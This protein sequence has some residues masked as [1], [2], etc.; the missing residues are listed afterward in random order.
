MN[1]ARLKAPLAWRL[2]L[3]ELR[4]GLSGFWVL[5]LCL[6]LGVAAI[7]GVASVRYSI[8]QGIQDEGQNILGG[9]AQME[10]T[11]R[12]ASDDEL[13]W[14]TQNA[15]AHSVV[16][17]FR[18]MLTHE[19]VRGLTDVK[20]VDDLYPLAGHVVLDPQMPLEDAF[21]GAGGLPGAVLDPLLVR[22]LELALGDTVQI[23]GQSFIYM[24]TL[25]REPDSAGAGFG[26]GPRSMVALSALEDTGL[27][28]PGTLFNTSYRLLAETDDLDQLRASAQTDL[29]QSGFQW[30]DKR[31]GAPGLSELVARLSAF[32]V[33]VGLA[34]LAVGGVGVSSA[35]R[36]YLDRK[37]HV[38]ATLKTLGAE[39]SL[40][41]GI[42]F[43]QIGL[44]TLIAVFA[45]LFV[46]ALFP[47][48]AVWAFGDQLPIPISPQ[49]HT[50]ALAEAASYGILTAAIF[51]LWP[52]A[53]ADRIRPAELYRDSLTNRRVWPAAR[54]L[55]AIAILLTTL[56]ALAALF[57]DNLKLVMWVTI[58]IGLS[59]VLLVLAARMIGGLSRFLAARPAL[60]AR[61][62]LRLALGAVGGPG[63][64][65]ASVVLSLGLGLTVLSAVGQID[66]NLR[67]SIAQELP[68]R[69][70]SYFV[71]DI[72]PTQIDALKARFDNDP[73]ITEYETA[74]MLRGLITEINGQNARD[75]AGSHWVLEGDRGI[76][77]ASAKPD[78]F[79]ITEGAFWP[80]R[81]DGPPQ[82]SFAA[83]EALEMGL[84]LG[85][86]LT[87]N[88]LGRDIVGELTSL[89]EVDFS[90]AGMGFILAMNE[91][92]LAGAPH[93]HIATVY[94]DALADGRIARWMA[95]DFPNTT[96]ISVRDAIS[97]VTE[98]MGSIASAITVAAGAT[99]VT[100]VV[101]LFGAVASGDAKRRY[102]AAL[103]KTLGA[104]RRDILQSFALRF[105]LMG[106]GA[107]VV[108]L[109][110]GSVATWA[111]M[112]FVM[113]TTFTL[114]LS[115][116]VTVIFIGVL[117]SA[118]AV[119][120][121]AMRALSV[122][123]ASVLR[124]QDG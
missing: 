67:A 1:K 31:D 24:A 92:A 94:G 73:D 106:F 60:R 3:R 20:A 37:I 32:L 50:G 69:A 4:G 28:Q 29:P 66:T 71:V 9:D 89:R 54:Y 80:D 81:Y 64:E 76:T 104:S 83:E 35:V 79:N 70:P 68:A 111:V 119:L 65:T 8:A 108:A 48:A 5:M 86:M 19:A 25:V 78:N 39:R 6:T 36:A 118:I 10:F 101:V 53:R 88:V 18:S 49:I 44:L 55:I 107:A 34:G 23:G 57:V 38:I 22:Q 95:K 115:N 11:Y 124:A 96:L 52:L 114:S 43:I 102:E 2:A 105:I 85:D 113:D 84:K 77:Y 120:A 122:S 33:L 93:S 74:P 12:F 13:A 42:Y 41:F 100:G 103:L 46:G 17:D 61:P 110:A 59:F 58:G 123:P 99:L 87:I 117:L 51:V 15:R 14:I 72:L 90:T 62:T 116:A 63:A 21:A 40:V 27:L 47:Y 16:A 56:V 98:L 112:R 91:S 109:F 30:R 82:I 45:G 7:A 97:R 26:F 75:V 121:L